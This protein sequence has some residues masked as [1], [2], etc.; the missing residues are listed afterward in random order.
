M[1]DLKSD[2][3]NALMF[4][5][6][7]GFEYLPV[8]EQAL[9]ASL[10]AGQA[11]Q[12]MTLDAVREEIG[13]C[14]RCR[15]AE[16][17]THIVFGEGSPDADLMFI[18]EGPGREEDLQA[19]PFVGEA[20]RLLTSLIEKLGMKRDNVYIANVVKCRPPMNRD[21]AEDEIAACIPFLK[22]QI[23]VIGP[24]A[25]MTLGRISTHAL[26]G[27]SI[28]ISRMR[29]HFFSYGDIPVM[30]TYHPAYLLRNRKAK[31]DTWDDAQKVMKVIK[32][33]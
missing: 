24:K 22:K 6:E 8:N 13:D 21:P 3:R 23:E 27:V 25:I 5:R 18:G 19:R 26:T 11:P 31:W 17:R 1:S 7:L 2:L 32:G 12:V 15:L 14:R 4:Y 9:M 33:G 29:G 16:N 10:R 30:P 20:G 28:P